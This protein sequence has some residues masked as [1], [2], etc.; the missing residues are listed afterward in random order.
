[1]PC[2]GKATSWRSNWSLTSS[3]NSIRPRSARNSGWQ[4]STWLRTCRTPFASC[5][6]STVRTRA[7]TSSTVKTLDP[8]RPDG[9]PLEER[10]GNVLPRLAGGQDGV[11]VSMRFHAVTRAPSRSM[12][13]R[14][15][16]AAATIRPEAIP[17]SWRR[18]A[19]GSRARRSRRSSTVTT[20]PGARA[21]SVRV[22]A[23]PE[24]PR[25]PS[26]SHQAA[27]GRDHA[28]AAQ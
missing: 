12:T 7:W 18:S 13:S 11:E 6:R 25:A 10:P 21:A 24:R 28:A 1:M 20:E 19:R 2:W 17:M 26:L 14:A 3:R 16:P 23:S 15:S 8:L 22:R 27:A 9:D 5:H 4:T